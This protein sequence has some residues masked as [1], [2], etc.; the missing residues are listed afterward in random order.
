MASTDDDS[1]H[2]GARW[3]RPDQGYGGGQFGGRP[4]PGPRPDRDAPGHPAT[5]PA[6][7][8]PGD[9]GTSGDGGDWE[10]RYGQ[11]AHADHT[12]DRGG[13]P[14]VKDMDEGRHADPTPRARGEGGRQAPEEHWDPDYRRCREEHARQLDD[15]YRAWRA[16]QNPG[17]GDGARG[18]ERRGAQREGSFADE[19]T[20]WRESRQRGG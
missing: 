2:R 18:D 12:P 10:G 5:G 8:G 14:T 3:G 20:R 4:G 15:D 17:P 13:G 6:N 1:G 16:M 19:F 11:R 7:G 9:G